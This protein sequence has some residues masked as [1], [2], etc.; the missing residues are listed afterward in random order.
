MTNGQKREIAQKVWIADIQNGEYTK[1]DEEWKPNYVLVGQLKVSRVNLIGTVVV[2]EEEGNRAL[3][4]LDDGTDKISLRTFEA[5]SMSDKIMVG[6]VVNV[7]GRP[8]QFGQEKYIVPESIK[9]VDPLWLK[10]R[11][12]EL[13]PFNPSPPEIHASVES[14]AKEEKSGSEQIFDLIKKMDKGD[15]AEFEQVISE[16]RKEGA[17]QLIRRLLE[18]GEIFEVRPGKLKILE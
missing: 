2:K 11:H 9:K 3:I 16:S 8:Y 10:V 5:L 13:K 4:W 14:T 15:G 12:S 17:E 1:D 7:V 6:D 18:E